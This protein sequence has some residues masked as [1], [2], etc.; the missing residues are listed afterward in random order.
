MFYFF[1]GFIYL[2]LERGEGREKE[3]ERNIDVQEIHWSVAFHMPPTGDP[4]PGMCP[5]WES[6]QQPFGLQAGTQS[7]EPHQPGLFKRCLI[8]TSYC[9]D[10]HSV[11]WN[12]SVAL[13]IWKEY[14]QRTAFFLV[15]SVDWLIVIVHRF[16]KRIL[17]SS[18]TNNTFGE[19]VFLNEKLVT[20][21]QV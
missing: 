10:W 11:S 9:T 2:F 7:T 20:L 16:F 1:K 12:L 8:F 14:T 6:N 5:D 15:P 4:N 3:R 17:I 21:W 19:R 18:N 13:K